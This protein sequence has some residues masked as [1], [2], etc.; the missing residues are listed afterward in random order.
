ATVTGVQTC[1]L[2]ILIHELKEYPQVAQVIGPVDRLPEQKFLFGQRYAAFKGI[3]DVAVAVVA[4]DTN[5]AV[6]ARPSPGNFPGAV[7]RAI[8]RKSVVWDMRWE[9]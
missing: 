2:P 9:W 1:A 5:V 3:S 4:I 6:L 7:G 8:D